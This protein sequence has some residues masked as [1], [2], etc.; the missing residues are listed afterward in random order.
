M[1]AAVILSWA[2]LLIVQSALA[3]AKQGRVTVDLHTP[4]AEIRQML[5]KHTPVGSSVDYVDRFISK[6][7]TVPGSGST[8]TVQAVADPSRPRAAKAIRVYLGHYYKNLGSIFLT[9]PMVVRERVSAQWWFDRH[10]RLIDIA[11]DKQASVY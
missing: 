4:P 10:G 9:A 1:R 3:D 6:Q 7:L 2:L 5:L 8:E 11:V